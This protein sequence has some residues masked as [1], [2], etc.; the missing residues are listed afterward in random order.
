M[1]QHCSNTVAQK[2][3]LQL[4]HTIHLPTESAVAMKYRASNRF[5]SRTKPLQE[6][7]N[8]HSTY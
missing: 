6:F 7:L 4:E 2:S 1:L 5:D 3:S 8:D